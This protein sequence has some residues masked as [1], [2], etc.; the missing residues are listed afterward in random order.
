MK[1]KK[2]DF[3]QDFWNHRIN[4]I[5]GYKIKQMSNGEKKSDYAKYE[6]KPLQIPKRKK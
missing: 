2:K 5:T 3:P 6:M 1:T 4:P